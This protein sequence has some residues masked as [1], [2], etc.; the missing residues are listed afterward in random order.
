MAGESRAAPSR[1]QLGSAASGTAVLACGGAGS[2]QKGCMLATPTVIQSGA[3]QPRG[4]RTD[5]AACKE[6][7]GF[8]ANIC[9]GQSLILNVSLEIAMH[10]TT[11]IKKPDRI[12]YT[13]TY[14]C[15]FIQ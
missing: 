13:F 9:L 5:A 7:G 10:S 4:A 1:Q 3:M 8:A 15:C 12:I 6:L 2:P 14:I 11:K